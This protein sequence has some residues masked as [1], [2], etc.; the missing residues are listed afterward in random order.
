M[1]E[2]G[3]PKQIN[4]SE[5]KTN[6]RNKRTQRA[7]QPVPSAGNGI[8]GNTYVIGEKQGKD[9]NAGN[10]KPVSIAVAFAV[11]RGKTSVFNT[12]IN[13]GFLFYLVT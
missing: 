8:T 10:M 1:Y 13:L 5:K 3:K 11:K 2:K 4:K 7:V 6:R 12:T 9:K